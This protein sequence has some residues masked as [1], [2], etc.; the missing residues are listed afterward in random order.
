MRWYASTGHRHT[1]AFGLSETISDFSKMGNFIAFVLNAL[2]V[3]PRPDKQGQSGAC[4]Y[5]EEQNPIAEA[6]V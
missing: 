6:G 2:R 1:G 5:H 4:D 3:A